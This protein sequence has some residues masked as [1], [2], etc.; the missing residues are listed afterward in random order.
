MCYG[1]D[2]TTCEVEQGEGGERN[3]TQPGPRDRRATD[4]NW[5]KANHIL[6]MMYRMMVAGVGTARNRRLGQC[7]VKHIRGTVFMAS[8]TCAPAGCDNKCSSAGTISLSPRKAATGMFHKNLVHP[9]D[10]Y[11]YMYMCVCDRFFP[12]C[13]VLLLLITGS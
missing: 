9:Y 2:I 1:Y 10:Q 11:I 13:S 6:T 4:R 7:V 12:L 5:R 3:Q 8:T